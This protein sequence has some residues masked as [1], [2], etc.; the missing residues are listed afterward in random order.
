MEIN[1]EELAK[2][3][4]GW[5]ENRPQPRVKRGTLG[6]YARLVKDASRGAVTDAEI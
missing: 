6:K 5:E 2:R 3:R 1:D 4:I